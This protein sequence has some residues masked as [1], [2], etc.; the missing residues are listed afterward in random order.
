MRAR[1][2]WL[3]EALPTLRTGFD[4]PVLALCG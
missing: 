4:L 3:H 1:C 2:Q